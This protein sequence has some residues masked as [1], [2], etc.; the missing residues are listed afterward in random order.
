MNSYFNFSLNQKPCVKKE[1]KIFHRCQAHRR[2]KT[3]HFKHRYLH[4]IGAYFKLEFMKSW[5]FTIERI[6]T[7]MIS[8]LSS[9]I[10]DIYDCAVSELSRKYQPKKSNLALRMNSIAWYNK[11]NLSLIF[12]DVQFDS[13]TTFHMLHNFIVPFSIPVIFKKNVWQVLQ[14]V[15]CIEYACFKFRPSK[16]QQYEWK[17]CELVCP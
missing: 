5:N 11:C 6:L 2:H 15:N 3:C 13:H 12:N 16:L 7:R 17:D 4:I 1:P 8:Q 10:K 9:Y 14:Y